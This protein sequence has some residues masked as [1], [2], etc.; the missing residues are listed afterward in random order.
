MTIRIAPIT[1]KRK[2]DF[3]ERWNHQ[4][5]SSQPSNESTDSRKNGMGRLASR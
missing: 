1:G 5:S 3:L 2:T 4:Q